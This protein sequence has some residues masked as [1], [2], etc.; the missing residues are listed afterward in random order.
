MTSQYSALVLADSVNPVAERI[1][2]L[3]I[4]MPLCVW[5]EFLTHRSLARNARSNRAVPSRVVIGEVIRNPFV[6]EHWGR[7]QKGMQ[8]SR[9]LSKVRAAIC[10]QIWLLSRWPAVV[11]VWLLTMLGLHKQDTNRLLAPWQWVDAVVTG[12]DEE[13]NAFDALRRHKDA[14]PKIHRIAELIDKARTNSVP[15]AL[16]WNEWHVP[17]YSHIQPAHR[18]SVRW[19]SVGACARVSYAAFDGTQ[20][21]EANTA[22]AQ[23]LE[24]ATPKHLSPFEHVVVAFQVKNPIKQCI[25]GNWMT[26]RH[27]YFE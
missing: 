22:L 24:E 14:D 11:A 8:A 15:Q 26:L 4:R 23:R 20:S 6:P 3:Q 13:W 7:N 5:A 2:T 10:R 27:G 18:S 9:T 17:Y 1:T 12:N 25:R 16:D 21:D 19:A